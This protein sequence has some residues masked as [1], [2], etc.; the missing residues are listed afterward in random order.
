MKRKWRDLQK[1]Y[2]TDYY[3]AHCYERTLK[4]YDYDCH[5]PATFGEFG[6]IG[7]EIKG[8]TLQSDRKPYGYGLMVDSG[9]ELVDEF[10]KLVR[11]AVSMRESDNLC[12]IIYTEQVDYKEEVNGLT[13]PQTPVPRSW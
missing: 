4:F 5:L 1:R 12:A 9:D 13:S 11:Q 2:N 6:G 7:Y 8:H 3:D 10:G